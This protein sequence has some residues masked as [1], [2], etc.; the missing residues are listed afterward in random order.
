MRQI[1]AFIPSCLLLH[2]IEIYEKITFKICVF[3][4]HNY[5]PYFIYTYFFKYY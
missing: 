2:M 4:F 5:N 1:F 3:A